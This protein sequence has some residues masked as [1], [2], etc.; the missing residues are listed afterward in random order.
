MKIGGLGLNIALFYRAIKTEN[1][2]LALNYVGR[3]CT[4]TEP[5]FSL[6]M[7]HQKS[8]YLSIY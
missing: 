7:K 4:G 5:I 1:Y 3:I 6:A 8:I 2:S